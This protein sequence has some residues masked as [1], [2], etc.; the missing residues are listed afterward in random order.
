MVILSGNGQSG[1]VSVGVMR[2][3]A[4]MPIVRVTAEPSTCGCAA[5]AR[6]GLSS[7]QSA[8]SDAVGPVPCSGIERQ[9]L[10]HCT[11]A[12]RSSVGSLRMRSPTALS[13][14]PTVLSIIGLTWA[15]TLT[16]AGDHKAGVAEVDLRRRFGSTRQAAASFG[17]ERDDD[18]AP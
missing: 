10:A 5:M 18:H 2:V 12:V 17:R 14:S 7:S 13:C 16:G 15:G 6:V 3:S 1:L 9:A 4:S 11:R 8:G